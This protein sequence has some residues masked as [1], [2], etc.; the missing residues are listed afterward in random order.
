MK[1]QQ[2]FKDANAA[3]VVCGGNIDPKKFLG[4]VG[5]PRR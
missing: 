4:L 2:R 1:E 5:N 3:L